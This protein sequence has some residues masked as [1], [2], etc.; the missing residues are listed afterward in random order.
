MA[1]AKG[2]SREVAAACARVERVVHHFGPGR[3]RRDDWEPGIGSASD[4][5]LSPLDE[6]LLGNLAITAQPRPKATPGVRLDG[7]WDLV[8]TRQRE[9]HPS[10]LFN[11]V[12]PE[13]KFCCL[14]C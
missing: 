6:E 11:V 1:N 13:Q 4:H 14:F 8:E 2:A 5:N 7:W 9:N 10:L 12:E 3:S